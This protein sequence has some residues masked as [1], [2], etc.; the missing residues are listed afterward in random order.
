MMRWLCIA[1]VVASACKRP[2]EERTQDEANVGVASAAGVDFVVTDGLA[3]FHVA[4]DG[5]V[6]LWA[7]APSIEIRGQVDATATRDWTI[8]VA[9]CLSDARLTA[10]LDGVQLAVTERR[11]DRPTLRSWSLS[12]PDPPTGELVVTITPPDAADLGPW[13][14]AAMADIQTGMDQVHEVFARINAETDVRFVVAMGDLVEDGEEEEY[15]LFMEQV[16]TL[17]VP[18]YSTNGNHELK[19]P[20]DRW[21]RRFGLFNVHFTFRGVTFS[22]VDSGNASLDL[23][24]YDRLDG[25]LDEARDGIHVFGTHIPP[26][27]PIGVRAGSFRSRTEAQKL[28]SKLAAGN[29]D[30]TLYGHIHSYY[31]YTNAGIPAYISG[32]GGASDEKLDGIDRHF[33]VI[34]ANPGDQ[35]LEVSRVNV[36][37]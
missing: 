15:E 8:E 20:P 1:L 21:S 34:D 33:L 19:G 30:L 22:L 9:N 24:V 35:T 28:L 36:D 16:K 23:L 10:T 7:Q 2:G 12:L 27:D 13:T 11:M 31:Q 18:F 29:V 3:Q 17:D 32:G 14:F 4:G 6:K 26:T 25:W 37:E 5:F